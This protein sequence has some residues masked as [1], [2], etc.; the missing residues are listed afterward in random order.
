MK[1]LVVVLAVCVCALAFSSAALA[2]S[3]TCAHGSGPCGQ[4]TGGKGT[5]PGQTNGAGTLPFTGLNLAGIGAVAGLLLI[6]G[7][8]L[9]QTSRRGHQ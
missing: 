1:R 9:L 7:V 6:S 2:N 5:G 4:G 8:A 3:L